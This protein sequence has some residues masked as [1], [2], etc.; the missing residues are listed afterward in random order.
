MQQNSNSIDPLSSLENCRIL[1]RASAIIF[2]FDGVIADSEEFQ[3]KIWAELLREDDIHYEGLTIA[4]IAGV[5]DRQAIQR[6]VPGLSAAYYD[7]LV[8]R[9]IERCRV[10]SHQ[11][12]LVPGIQPLLNSLV[13]HKQLHICSSS[14]EIDIRRFL[15]RSLPDVPFGEVVGKRS[16]PRVKPAPDP[17]LA[18]LERVGLKSNQVVAI[19][20]SEVGARAAQAAGISVICFDRY[21]LY[22]K[23]VGHVSSSL[24]D[25]LNWQE[26]GDLCYR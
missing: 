20:D 7:N 22:S 9:K 26:A 18:T 11:I 5:P 1:A 16:Y 21:G 19:E 15:K 13:G 4:A 10:R 12:R 17:Y 25:L 6:A 3:L 2:D 24:F 23:G 8:K 14:D